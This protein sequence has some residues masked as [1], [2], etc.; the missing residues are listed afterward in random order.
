MLQVATLTLIASLFLW[1]KESSRTQVEIATTSLRVV[2]SLTDEHLHTNE[3]ASRYM[4]EAF[5][6]MPQ[7]H[8]FGFVWRQIKGFYATYRWRLTPTREIWN[9]PFTSGNENAVMK[10]LWQFI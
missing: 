8:T 1:W 3:L 10:V 2:S 5:Y 6:N 4:S 9:M 7:A